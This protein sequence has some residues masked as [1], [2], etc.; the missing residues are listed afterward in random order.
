[1]LVN[2]RN[3]ASKQMNRDNFKQKYQSDQMKEA[4]TSNSWL[5]HMRRHNT[6]QSGASNLV[7]LLRGLTRPTAQIKRT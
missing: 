5:F 6:L 3:Y 7:L 1:M 4:V 2:L